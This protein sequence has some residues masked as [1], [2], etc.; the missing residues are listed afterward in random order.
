MKNY[1]RP[2]QIGLIILISLASLGLMMGYVQA[3]GRKPVM[4]KDINPSGGTSPFFLT[5]VNGV[6]YFFADDGSHGW[7]LWKSNGTAAGT[8]MVKDIN[9]SGDSIFVGNAFPL[10]ISDTLYFTAN[11]GVHGHELWQSDGTAG[12][13]K[14]VAD[15]NPG[16]E[17]SNAGQFVNLNDMLYFGA[18]NAMY[19]AELWQSNGTLAG[20]KIVTD[21]NSGPTSSFFTDSSLTSV[22]GTLFFVSYT[23]KFL[24]LW[25][26]DGTAGGTMLVKEVVPGNLP[27]GEH[28]SHIDNIIYFSVEKPI[29]CPIPR[30]LWKSDGTTIGTELVKDIHPY[31]FHVIGDT[32]YLSASDSPHG[33][34]LWK[35]DGTLPGTVLIK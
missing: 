19:G 18:F 8:V 6:L 28:F 26:S 9:P 23:G 24:E 14:L 5:N 16:V 13:T 11:D 2:I 22:D 7:E 4:V 27:S 10:P 35:S 33:R 17:S 29:C 15:I 3:V 20:T 1:R 12:G 31:E 32:L 25:K 30:E 34:E 21:I